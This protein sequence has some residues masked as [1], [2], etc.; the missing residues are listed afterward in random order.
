MSKNK[1]LAIVLVSGG[2]DSL[3]T[4]ALAS[5]AHQH[6]AFLHLNYGQKTEKKVDSN[7][8]GLLL[9]KMHK[10]RRLLIS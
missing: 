5:E 9:K 2:M 7:A 10:E 4:A 6:L 3:V 8:G 1:E